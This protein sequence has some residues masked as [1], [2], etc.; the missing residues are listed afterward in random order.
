MNISEQNLVPLEVELQVLRLY[1]GIMGERFGDRVT[2]QWD[3]VDAARKDTL[4]VL[5]LQP[6]LE[7][8]F[9]HGVESHAGV[10]VITISAHADAQHVHLSIH[11]DGKLAAGA[12]E[13]I[14]LTNCRR[15]L[16]SH[17]G[18]AA[19]LTLESDPAGGVV[20]RLSLPR[21]AA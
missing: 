2:V 18:D 8:A 6:L 3:I 11:N 9:R 5:M 15:R 16:R 12:R 14:G 10:H 4:P 1:A 19:R 17:Y 13:G 7:N 21:M 20:S